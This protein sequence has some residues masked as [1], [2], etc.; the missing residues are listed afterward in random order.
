MQ[1]CIRVYHRVDEGHLRIESIKQ[2]TWSRVESE[3][4]ISHKEAF[5]EIMCNIILTSKILMA[6]F[7]TERY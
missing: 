2:N 5:D 4:G 3:S 6:M 7:L 1:T